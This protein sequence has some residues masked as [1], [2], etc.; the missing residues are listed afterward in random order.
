MDLRRRAAEALGLA[1]QG[2]GAPGRAGLAGRLAALLATDPEAEVRREAALS[3]GRLA[4]DGAGVVEALAGAS[5]SGR[6]TNAAT[7]LR[8]L[9]LCSFPCGGKKRE[10]FTCAR[11]VL[12]PSG[13]CV[14]GAVMDVNGHVK[15]YA[16]KALERIGTPAALRAA[17]G[18]LLVVRYA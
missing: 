8:L 7:R 1:G 17:V 3:L 2:A 14:A 11:D 13:L 10:P 5:P 18:H 16:L 9:P 4:T 12:T 6:F 15:G